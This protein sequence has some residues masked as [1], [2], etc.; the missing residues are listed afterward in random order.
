MSLE[1]ILE[2][3]ETQTERQIAQLEQATQAKIEQIQAQAHTEAETLQQQQL[4]NIQPALQAEQARL[5]N[6]A[7][8]QAMQTVTATREAAILTLIEAVTQQLA[9]LSAG[10]DYPALLRCL[11]QEAVATLPGQDNLCLHVK[12]ADQELMRQLVQGL[13]LTATILADLPEECTRAWRTPPTMKINPH[14]NPSPAAGEGLGEGVF[15]KGHHETNPGSPNPGLGGLVVSTT[16]GRIRL[17]N[18]LATRLQRASQLYRSQFAQAL[19]GSPKE[20][21]RT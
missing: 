3:L 10:P 15:T 7:R 9:T 6:Q 18:T 21:S 5:L 1:H 8:V 19:F 16:N 4:Q 2:A 12:V 17:D 14:P 13:G 20:S 11:T